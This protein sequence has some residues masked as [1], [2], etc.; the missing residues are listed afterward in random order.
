MPATPVPYYNGRDPIT[1]MAKDGV[2]FFQATIIDQF[3]LPNLN[4]ISK[5]DQQAYL[6]EIK[7]TE[8]RIGN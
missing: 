8:L 4:K 6:D 7:K 3:H 5:K 1:V 2:K